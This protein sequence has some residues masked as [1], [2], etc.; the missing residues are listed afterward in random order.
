[1][2]IFR[3]SG[4][5]GNQLWSYAA[6]YSLAKQRGE[7]FALDTST[8]EADWFFRDYD[9][10]HYNI[11]MDKKIC[12]RLGDAKKDHLFW[13]HFYRRKALGLFTPT[14]K[15]RDKSVYDPGNFDRK[16]RTI[17]YIGD[18]QH[19]EY[20]E[21][22]EK[23]I[24]RMYVYQDPL[25]EAA[26]EI[27]KEVSGMKQSVAI[28]VRRGDYVR[29]GI[30]LGEEYYRAA[31]EKM[32]GCL[33]DPVFYCFS[34]DLEW[35][36][37]AFA[38]M[39]YQFRYMEYPSENKGLE[40]FELIRACSHQII[41]RSSYSWWGAFLNENIDKIVIYPNERD[42]KDHK[43]WSDKWLSIKC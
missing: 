37:N 28:H 32:A 16:G 30:A 24:R 21:K 25:S 22:Y 34:E 8:Q 31:V 42:E 39:P 1:M 20:F 41:S 23:D 11:T 6:G 14:V 7:L 4:G 27:K 18:W 43:T 12:Y 38:G 17:Y 26:S 33:S 35:V 2:I 29:I 36:R 19:L 40:D 13:N 15:E 9:I 3:L 5:F 10:A